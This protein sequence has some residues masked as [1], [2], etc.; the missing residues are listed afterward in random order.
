MQN[1]QGM[2][3]R[4]MRLM[5]QREGKVPTSARSSSMLTDISWHPELD[6]PAMDF[7]KIMS[8]ASPMFQPDGVFFSDIEVLNAPE[9][10]SSENTP[11]INSHS[12]GQ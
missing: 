4:E 12:Q 8:G 1:L 7:M 3:Q 5:D 11:T 2:V 9:P 6:D 10:A